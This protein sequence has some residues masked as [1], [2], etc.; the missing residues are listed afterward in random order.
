[1]AALILRKKII[2]AIGDPDSRF[3]ED[4]LRMLRAVR[5]AANLGFA[6]DPA[7]Q[8]AIERNAAKIKANQR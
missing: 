5:F 1:M 2:R 7:T 3:N 4:F 8:N 6:I